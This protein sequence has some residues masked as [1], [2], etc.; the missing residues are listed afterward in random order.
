MNITPDDF[1]VVG[2]IFLVA[3]IVISIILIFIIAGKDKK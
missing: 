3:A 1:L 2:T